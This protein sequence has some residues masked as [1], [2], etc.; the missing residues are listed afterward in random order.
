MRVFLF[1]KAAKSLL[2]IRFR[3]FGRHRPQGCKDLM[4]LFSF[5]IVQGIWTER[6]ARILMDLIFILPIDSSEIG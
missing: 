3:G 2:R 1:P 6:N 5:A 4:A